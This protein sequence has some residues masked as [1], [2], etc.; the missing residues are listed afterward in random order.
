MVEH[1]MKMKLFKIHLLEK[2]FCKSFWA[3]EQH[4]PSIIQKAI[5]YCWKL[6]VLPQNKFGWQPKCQHMLL[7]ILLTIIKYIWY[8][9][10]K[11][12]IPTMSLYFIADTLTVNVSVL[13]LSL[14]SPDESS[15]VSNNLFCYIVTHCS[16][17]V[18]LYW[19]R[20]MFNID[21]VCV[22]I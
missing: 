10:T 5:R 18:N 7:S 8:V 17:F 3:W 12:V 11:L 2:L 9:C 22:F 14:A 16:S 13:L 19:Y 15:L 21:Q 4:F 6:L 20:T 1:V